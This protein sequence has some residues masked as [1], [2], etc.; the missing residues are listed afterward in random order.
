[1]VI[2]HIANWFHANQF[3]LNVGKMNIVK[4]TQFNILCN[5]WTIVYDGRLLIKV[6][7]FKFLCLFVDKHLNWKSHIN[8][9]PSK[10]KSVCYT[11]KQLSSV[12]NIEVLR[13]V[14]FANFPSLLYYGSIFWGS[15]SP[16][17]HIFLLQKRIIRIMVGVTSKCL[18]R[19]LFRKLDTLS[20]PHLYIYLLMMCVVNNLDN[21]NMNSSV[22]R[23][24]ARYKNQLHRPVAELSYFQKGVFY[25]GIKIFNILPSTVLEHKN[26]KS[27]FKAS[28]R[29][30]LVANFFYSHAK[31]FTHCHN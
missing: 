9:L 14:Y 8:K 28:L 24:Y 3:I 27:Q 11:I 17:G 19:S 31:F 4:F 30:F 5:P 1:M 7:Y 13:I 15:S 2:S 12:L 25:F 22:H 21:Y 16:G 26:Y 6:L 29:K 20:L 18:C 23:I 10:L